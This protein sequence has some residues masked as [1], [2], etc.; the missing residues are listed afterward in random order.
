MKYKFTSTG[1]M[2]IESKEEMKKRG[3]A[4]PDRAD[5]VCLTFAVEAASI[6]HFDN[7]VG[8]WNKPLQRNLSMV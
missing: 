1:K 7:K 6:I 2:Q 3:M 8:N 4:S 5:A